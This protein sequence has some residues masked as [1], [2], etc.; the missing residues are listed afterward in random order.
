MVAFT[1]EKIMKKNHLYLDGYFYTEVK[2][3]ISSHCVIFLYLLDTSENHTS[4][5][6]FSWGL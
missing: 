6:M 3:L 2:L 1:I 5:L 4:F